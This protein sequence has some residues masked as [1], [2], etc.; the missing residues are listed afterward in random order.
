[1]QRLDFNKQSSKAFGPSTR[2]THYHKL[3]RSTHEKK[4]VKPK[5]KQ[6]NS[7]EKSNI[8]TLHQYYLKAQRHAED[9]LETVQQQLHQKYQR[10]WKDDFGIRP[11]DLVPYLA[12]HESAPAKTA[13][14][15]KRHFAW[16]RLKYPKRTKRKPKPQFTPEEEL[17][18]EQK[19]LEKRK[20]SLRIFRERIK[21]NAEI[22]KANKDKMIQSKSS[23]PITPPYFDYG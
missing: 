23:L 2:M 20:N 13:N 4:R 19:I 3:C 22:D 11:T 8:Q 21:R 9:K 14:A 12:E 6:R 1:M 16:M 17:D 5:K 10:D 7:K 15:E 18:R